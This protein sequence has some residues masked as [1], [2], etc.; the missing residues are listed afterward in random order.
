[1]TNSLIVIFRARI[2]DLSEQKI[3]VILEKHT[4][5]SLK[6]PDNNIVHE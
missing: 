6:G 3:S 5:Y 1:M 4:I 2:L